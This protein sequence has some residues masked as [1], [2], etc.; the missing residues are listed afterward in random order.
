MKVKK[1]IKDSTDVREKYPHLMSIPDFNMKEYKKGSCFTRH[2]A[3]ELL[4]IL[5][6]YGLNINYTRS[7]GMNPVMFAIKA[8]NHH[9]LKLLMQ[10]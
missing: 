8:G 1:G 10:V 3:R 6:E 7:D 4:M 5:L 2:T 9:L